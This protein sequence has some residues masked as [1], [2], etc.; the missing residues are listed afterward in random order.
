M[1][2]RTKHRGEKCP[3]LRVCVGVDGYDYTRCVR[4]TH[5]HTVNAHSFQPFWGPFFSS[6]TSPFFFSTFGVA[7]KLKTK[8]LKPNG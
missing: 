3:C 7:R 1:V 8:A 6:L 2:E 5:T 4:H